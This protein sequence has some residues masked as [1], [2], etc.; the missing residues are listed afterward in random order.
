MC[1]RNFR[2]PGGHARVNYAF[3]FALFGAAFLSSSGCDPNC[4][5]EID[6]VALQLI[7]DGFVAPVGMAV[8][9][10]GT[11]RL[12]ILD[13]IGTITIINADGTKRAT[14]FLDLS[15]RMVP[16]G[17]DLGG[18]FIFD[19]RGLLGL[20][21]HPDYRN[22]GRFFVFYTAPKDAGDP[23]EF[24]AQTHI[25]EFQVSDDPNVADAGSE[26]ILLEID[27]PQFNHNGGQLEFGADGLLY[28]GVGDGGNA[29][30]EGDGHNPTIGNAQDKSTLLGKILRIDVDAGDPYEIPATNPF[31][32]ESG[33]LPE[34]YAWGLRN[35]WRFSF[36]S[37]GR[38]FVG[39]VGQ[40]LFEEVD[41][42]ESGRNYGWR[43]RE[44][45]NCFD[46]DNP[47]DPPAT[48]DTTGAGGAALVDPIIEYPHSAEEQPFG[49]S[50][51]GG[52]LYEGEAISCLKGQYVFGDWSTNFT[53]AD[54]T[55]FAAKENF[56]GSWTT[57]ELAIAG[58]E[59][60][61][62]GRFITSFGRDLN[63]ELYIFTSANFGPVGTTGR[64][65]K[66]VAAE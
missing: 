34:I 52:Y 57:R 44:G 28:I 31:V 50:V 27:K 56:D 3:A 19:E 20:A 26:R 33:T 61:R 63:G 14:P 60:G 21:F 30:D 39:D 2:A 23:A 12:F 16:V 66:L 25:S 45:D 29:N 48:C 17:L 41:I 47:A 49:I 54:G 46:A 38:L 64:V 37:Q 10:D 40:D 5:A 1:H 13:Q 43:I 62:I 11:G 32:S 59:S 53:T 35:P 4:P 24:N 15:A 55:L 65:H 42:V 8:P 36:D 22:N 58:I 7:A 51:T 9:D 18:G 6:S